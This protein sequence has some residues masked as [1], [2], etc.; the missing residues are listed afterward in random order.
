MSMCYNLRDD[1]LLNLNLPK[2]LDAMVPVAALEK[3]KDK[4]SE[5]RSKKKTRF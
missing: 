2:M 1:F 4:L 5:R 3:I